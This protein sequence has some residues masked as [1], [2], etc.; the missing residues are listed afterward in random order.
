MKEPPWLLLD[1]GQEGHGH[2]EVPPPA[3]TCFWLE[4]PPVWEE[5]GSEMKCILG[6]TPRAG[7]YLS[8]GF[9]VAPMEGTT[10]HCRALPGIIRP[11]AP[12]TQLPGTRLSHPRV[13]TEAPSTASGSLTELPLESPGNRTVGGQSCSSHTQRFNKGHKTELGGCWM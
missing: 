13:L 7:P 3:E 12:E 5:R 4:R 10:Q 11:P 6:E 2:R 1:K 9:G 8:A